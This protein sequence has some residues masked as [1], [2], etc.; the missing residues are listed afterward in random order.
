MRNDPTSL[1]RA[2]PSKMPQ[3]VLRVSSPSPSGKPGCNALQCA[4]MSLPVPTLSPSN[5]LPTRRSHV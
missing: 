2:T 4:V 5:G 3:D 1:L